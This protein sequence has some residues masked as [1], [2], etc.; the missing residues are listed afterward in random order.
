MVHTLALKQCR[1]KLHTFCGQ[2]SKD[3]EMDILYTRCFKTENAIT[4]KINSKIN[5]EISSKKK[6]PFILYELLCKFRYKGRVVMSVT[7]DSFYRLG[8]SEGI[9]IQVDTCEITIH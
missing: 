8:N 7:E 6:K 3:G 1:Q 9:L 5:L 2:A 4:G